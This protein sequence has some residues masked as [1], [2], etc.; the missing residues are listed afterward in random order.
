VDKQ[1]FIGVTYGG[2]LVFQYRT[3]D[4]GA[5]T[6]HEYSGYSV[7]STWVKLVKMPAMIYGL[8]STDSINFSKIDSLPTTYF[9]SPVVG[10]AYSCSDSSVWGSA[11]QRWVVFG[12][13]EMKQSKA[14]SIPSVY[15]GDT[16]IAGDR[17]RFES[18]TIGVKKWFK[19]GMDDSIIGNVTVSGNA[20]LE[21]RARV[22]GNITLSGNLTAINGASYSGKLTEGAYVEFE[23]L[24]QKTFTVGTSSISVANNKSS[25]ISG[26][27][28]Y[29]NVYIDSRGSLVINAGIYYFDSLY[30]NTDAKLKLNGHV[31][32]N[33]QKGILFNDRDSVIGLPAYDKVFYSNGTSVT[34]G[35]ATVNGYFTAP[36]AKVTLRSKAVLKGRIAAKSLILEND[37][38]VYGQ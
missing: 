23:S 22:K 36:N 19:A 28:K 18:D 7:G 20:R 32:I 25:T 16:I 17:V 26:G 11:G 2:K 1:V 9:S 24:S 15:A 29:K 12:N 31:E 33:V 37:S 38:K 30:L 34:F 13:M 6:T 10:F 4:S 35:E 8:V 3:T 5:T 14:M 21:D 27:G